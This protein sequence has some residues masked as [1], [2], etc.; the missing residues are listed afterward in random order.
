MKLFQK[1]SKQAVSFPELTV[2]AG[3]IEDV[4]IIPN[5][6]EKSEKRGPK[7]V[8]ASST[9]ASKSQF[10]NAQ[11][12]QAS[13]QQPSAF[14]NAQASKQPSSTATTAVQSPSP[15]ATPSVYASK[16]HTFPSGNARHNLPREEF[17]FAANLAR[18]DK[19]NEFKKIQAEDLVPKDE[20]LVAIN[21][22]QR[23]LGIHENVL[24]SGD[25]GNIVKIAIAK[26]PVNPLASNPSTANSNST[27][28]ANS[29]A[30]VRSSGS[31]VSV[32]DEIMEKFK[33]LAVPSGKT[34]SKVLVEEGSSSSESEPET[35]IE[36]TISIPMIDS[37]KF[38][39]LFQ[40]Q[41]ESFRTIS[42]LNLSHH[43]LAELDEST[44]IVLLLGVDESSAI[45]MES[46]YH[47][48]NHSRLKNVEIY[49]IFAAGGKG[50]A[51]K[52]IELSSSTKSARKRL[53]SLEKVKFTTNLADIIKLQN[54][55][56]FDSLGHEGELTQNAIKGL[57]E[58]MK[59][60]L[61]TNQEKDKKIIYG[62]ESSLLR[63]GSTYNNLQ[64][65]TFGMPR[66]SLTPS[67]PASKSIIYVDAGLPST[68]ETCEIFNES[69][70]TEIEY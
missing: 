63:G 69:F 67:L 20:R 70:V 38:N 10:A 60:L 62:I 27:A 14:S 54:V 8:Q 6:S 28:N 2:F 48:C 45:L 47:L 44:P 37:N 35:K 51:G 3:N 22:P 1:R 9:P 61:L 49:A 7:T 23:K 68:G 46:F 21:S 55:T 5:S 30:N 32:A 18:F 53:I 19:A 13:K 52:R 40:E 66:D 58:W 16:A 42:A 41:A 59:K 17:D 24:E 11:A 29:N 56:V 26:K 64:L 43:L 33:H 57:T 4:E 15:Y 39:S 50:S 12:Q 25:K 31:P 34:S 36:R 65:V